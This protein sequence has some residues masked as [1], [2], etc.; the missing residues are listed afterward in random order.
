M[1]RTMLRIADAE[2]R[3]TGDAARRGMSKLWRRL[4]FLIRR[5]RFDRDLQDEIRLHLEMKTEAGGGSNEAR[6]AARRQFGNTLLLR[7]SSR[8]MW[9]WEPLDRLGQD[10]RYGVRMLRRNPGFAAVAVLTL[11]LGIGA[12]TAIFSVLNAVLIR[13]LP[14]RQPEELLCM[15]AIGERGEDMAFSYPFFLALR[16]SQQVFSSVYAATGSDPIAGC[17]RGLCTTCAH[18]MPASRAKA[19]Y[20]W[21]SSLLFGLAPADPTTIAISMFLIFSVAALAGYVP[22]RRAARVGPMEALGNE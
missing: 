14:V 8:E 13:E 11:A 5:E 22:A 16:K 19:F 7:E 4:L 9:G 2:T 6:Y 15:A 17:W 21:I 12:N 1:R 3:R 10:L 20:K 18:S